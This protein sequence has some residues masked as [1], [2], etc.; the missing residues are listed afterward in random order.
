MVLKT[1]LT[2]VRGGRAI[3]PWALGDARTHSVTWS[4]SVDL[5]ALLSWVDASW[6]FVG[7]TWRVCTSSALGR[8]QLRPYS[9]P[10]TGC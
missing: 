7:I 3:W 9:F 5:G 2:P 6:G 8:W 4:E 1:S 10:L